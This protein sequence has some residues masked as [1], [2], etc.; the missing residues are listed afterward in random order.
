MIIINIIISLYLYDY[1][2]GKKFCHQVILI[3][4]G[5]VHLNCPSFWVF[6][7]GVALSLSLPDHPMPGFLCS[8]LPI[9]LP[10][11]HHP[12]LFYLFLPVVRPF[13]LA[14]HAVMSTNREGFVLWEG[15]RRERLV[16]MF[17]FVWWWWWGVMGFEVL[18]CTSNEL[19]WAT[20]WHSPR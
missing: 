12:P 2:E 7:T 20:S 9:A 10:P 1:Y 13:S 4:S 15:G 14:A 5:A 11:T 16:C 8:S 3:S 6:Q 18:A 17:V 19:W